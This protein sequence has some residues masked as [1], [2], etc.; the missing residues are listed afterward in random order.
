MLHL[1][2]VANLVTTTILL[3]GQAILGLESVNR[4]LEVK[5]LRV[6]FINQ[7][8]S[9]SKSVPSRANGLTCNNKN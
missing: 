2:A 1:M 9:R 3:V 6:G 7:T 5:D 4:L 8:I